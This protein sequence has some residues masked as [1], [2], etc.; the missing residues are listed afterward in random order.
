MKSISLLKYGDAVEGTSLLDVPEP[1]NP[2]PGEVL[3]KV[4]YA[5]INFNDLMVPWGIYPWKPATPAVLGTEGAGTVVALGEGVE[6]LDVGA[7]VVL[8]FGSQT[9]RERLVA[10]AEDLVAVPDEMSTE[11]AS[12]LAINGATAW[13]LLHD[14]VDLRPGDGIV[15]SAATSG[16]ARWLIAIAKHLGLY[17][18]GLVRSR[19]DIETVKAAGCDFVFENDADL[20]EAKALM[21]D[22]P[23][24]L[25]LDVVGGSVSGKV[26]SLVGAHGRFISYGAISKT[27]M[28]MPVGNLTFKQLQISGFFLGSDENIPKVVPALRALLSIKGIGSIKQPFAGIFRPEEAKTAIAQAQLGRRVLLDFRS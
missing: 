5:P 3:V 18:A 2:G 26:A 17:T 6:V 14:Y 8:P 9:W 27:P 19:A 28:E 10:R 23:I 21:R 22:I 25:G 12:V 4:D 13:L 15:F 11:Q 7:R 24:R 1:P 16:V 20:A